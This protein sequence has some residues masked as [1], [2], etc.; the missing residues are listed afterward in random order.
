ML[1]SQGL[2]EVSLLTMASYRKPTA[3][4]KG[5]LSFKNITET[6][7]SLDYAS[8]HD[9]NLAAALFSDE[10]SYSL[11]LMPFQV[12]TASWLQLCFLME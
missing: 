2:A 7:T 3:P 8:V 1:V 6:T 10:M 4:S 5:M 9:S 11:L 12:M